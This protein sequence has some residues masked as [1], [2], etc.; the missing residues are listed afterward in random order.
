MHTLF[1]LNQLR[2]TDGLPGEIIDL[3]NRAEPIPELFG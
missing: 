2:V 1:D 3:A